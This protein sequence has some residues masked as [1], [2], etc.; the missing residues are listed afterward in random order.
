[1]L[2]GIVKCKNGSS[3]ILDKLGDNI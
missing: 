3:I 2:Y 1:M